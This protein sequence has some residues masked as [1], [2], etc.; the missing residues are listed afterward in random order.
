MTIT[1]EALASAKAITVYGFYTANFPSDDCGRDLDRTKTFLDLYR[2]LKAHEDVYATIGIADSVVRE[3]LF[4]RLAKILD[5][6]Y[7]EIY[8]LWLSEP[9]K[10]VRK[11]I[12]P[13]MLYEMRAAFGTGTTVVNVL[14]GEKIAL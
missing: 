10:P 11:V 4:E 9:K 13:E 12:D 14:T 1:R 7:S 5:A 3:R 8:D 2:A 6:D